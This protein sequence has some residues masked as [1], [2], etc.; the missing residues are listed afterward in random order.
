MKSHTFFKKIYIAIN[1]NKYL[2]C[3]FYY[4]KM[5]AL[6]KHSVINN[7]CWQILFVNWKSFLFSWYIITMV[8][9]E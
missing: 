1:Q 4:L 5:A 9:I 2:V 3:V 7:K 8:S 6:A